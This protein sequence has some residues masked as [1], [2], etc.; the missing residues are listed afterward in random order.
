MNSKSN[1]NSNSDSQLNFHSTNTFINENPS[2]SNAKLNSN[3]KLLLIQAIPN[4]VLP[5]TFLME[6]PSINIYPVSSTLTQIFLPN[7]FI[8]NETNIQTL[9]HKLSLF[10]EII[11]IEEMPHLSLLNRWTS[12][13]VQTA[14]TQFTTSNKIFSSNHPLFSLPVPLTGDGQVITITD[15]GLD[16]KHFLFANDENNINANLVENHRKIVKYVSE[17]RSDTVEETS[18]HGTHVSGIAAGLSVCSDN[19]KSHYNGVAPDA[20]ILFYDIGKNNAIILPNSNNLLNIMN[21]YQSYISSNSWSLDEENNVLRNLYDTISNT[22]P[23][24]L[25]VFAAGNTGKN[26]QVFA[27]SSS[28]NTLTIGALDSLPAT[29]NILQTDKACIEEESTHTKICGTTSSKLIDQVNKITPSAINSADLTN[30]NDAS[31]AN[32]VF[33]GSISNNPNNPLAVITSELSDLTANVNY[34]IIY[35]QL[36]TDLDTINLWKTNNKK[37]SIYPFVDDISVNIADYSS[38]GPTNLGAIK[39]EVLAPG[40]AIYSAK[41]F[42]NIGCD[43]DSIFDGLITKDGTS[44]ATP[45]ASGGLILLHQYFKNKLGIDSSSFATSN[46]GVTLKA[47]AIATARKQFSTVSSSN[48]VLLSDNDNDHYNDHHNDHQEPTNKS[49]IHQQINKQKKLQEGSVSQIPDDTY[50][51]GVLNIGDAIPEISGTKTV[52]IDKIPLNKGH[53]SFT[54]TTTDKSHDLRIVVSWPDYA[55]SSSSSSVSLVQDI[56]LVVEDPNNN[57]HFIFGNF[58]DHYSSTERVVIEKDDIEIGTY[59]VHLYVSVYNNQYLSPISIAIIGPVQLNSESMEST[60]ADIRTQLSTIKTTCPN[61]CSQ[62]GGTCQEGLCKCGDDKSGR[63]CQ[64][65]RTNVE[66]DQKLTINLK[67]HETA[68][69]KT[70]IDKINYNCSIRFFDLSSNLFANVIGELNSLVPF[71]FEGQALLNQNAQALLLKKG[72][73]TLNSGDTVY[74]SIFNLNPKQFTGQFRFRIDKPLDDSSSNNN[75]KNDNNPDNKNNKDNNLVLIIG[76]VVGGVVIVAVIV[77]VIIIFLKKKKTVEEGDGS[78]TVS[79]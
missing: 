60:A 43:T 24:F 38:R 74:F 48:S 69:F 29:I 47:L 54:L 49:L 79:V 1:L 78:R 11:S 44:M 31:D 39:P 76:L 63:V 36:A 30:S 40:T 9:K 19:K 32:K 66:P 27:P 8:L 20:K 62:N 4:F 34:P 25:H 52:L 3:S 64:L 50:G 17:D 61:K 14:N 12:G 46:Y 41:A 18:G 57:L 13:Y 71:E 51:Y 68:Y 33:I 26:F 58:E 77:I 53:Y 15:S 59:T 22:Y 37:V 42:S 70:K 10:S 56:D 16:Y 28:K 35:I 45:A 55:G 7:S 67:S 75:Q 73:W 2:E 72:E 65:T 21:T 23:G 5:Q 6:F